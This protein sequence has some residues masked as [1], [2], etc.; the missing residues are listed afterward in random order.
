M[1]VDKQYESDTKPNKVLS[2]KASTVDEG[3]TSSKSER[4]VFITF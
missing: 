3:K 2:Y 1:S 4:Y